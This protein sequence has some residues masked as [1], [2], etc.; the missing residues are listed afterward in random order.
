MKYICSQDINTKAYCKESKSNVD[1]V[2]KL[3]LK[4]L[5]TNHQYLTTINP[6]LSL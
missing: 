3:K 4:A 2:G 6:I 5:I 1:S